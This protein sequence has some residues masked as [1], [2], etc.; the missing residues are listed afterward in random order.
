[1]QWFPCSVHDQQITSTTMHHKRALAALQAYLR[2]TKQPWKWKH[3]FTCTPS[4]EMQESESKFLT[5]RQWVLTQG[6]C[7]GE[8]LVMGSKKAVKGAETADKIPSHR[9]QTKAKRGN[10]ASTLHLHFQVKGFTWTLH[11]D[12]NHGNHSWH[13]TCN[14]VSQASM[15]L[16]ISFQRIMKDTENLVEW[17]DQS[18]IDWSTSILNAVIGDR[19]NLLLFCKLWIMRF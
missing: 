2:Q 6:W 19:L 18:V 17:S 14:S 5:V 11:D 16:N 15:G 4:W 3:S 8:S 12:H 10:P 1:M 13:W 7:G 9:W